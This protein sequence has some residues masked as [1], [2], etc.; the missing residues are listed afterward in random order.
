M[1]DS[2]QPQDPAS[3]LSLEALVQ[4]VAAAIT[5]AQARIDAAHL[6]D[7]EQFIDENGRSRTLTVRLPGPDGEQVVDIPLLSFAAP[8][9]LR[10]TEATLA[11]EI[12]PAGLVLLG[13]SVA[14]LT[15]DGF[16]AHATVTPSAADGRRPATMTLRLEAIPAPA[17]NT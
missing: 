5:E 8:T 11:F 10:V 15:P 3:P 1:S 6:A 2:N 14:D 7:L 17:A 13:A 4:A 9:A 12:D 16:A